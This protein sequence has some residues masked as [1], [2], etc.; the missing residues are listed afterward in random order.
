MITLSKLPLRLTD[1]LRLVGCTQHSE[2]Q[3]NRTWKL[4]R[5]LEVVEHEFRED[6]KPV[7]MLK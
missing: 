3:S 5:S 2:D 1:E 7:V 4:E 6:T